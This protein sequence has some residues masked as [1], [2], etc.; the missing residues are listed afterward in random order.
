MKSPQRGY[1]FTIYVVDEKINSSSDGFSIH[2]SF[3]KNTR[4]EIIE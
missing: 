1:L 2:A 3:P 4:G